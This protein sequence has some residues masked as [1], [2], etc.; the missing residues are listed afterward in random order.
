MFLSFKTSLAFIPEYRQSILFAIVPNLL[1][2]NIEHVIV[3]KCVTNFLRSTLTGI[4]DGLNLVGAKNK[5]LPMS[6][7]LFTYI[8]SLITFPLSKIM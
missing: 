8:L 2:F 7:I 3:G 1:D 5:F 6:I 4:G